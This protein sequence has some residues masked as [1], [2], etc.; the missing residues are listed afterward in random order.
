MQHCV[1]TTSNRG[2]QGRAYRAAAAP[3]VKGRAAVHQLPP[4]K[5][6]S[7]GRNEHCDGL[8]MR[9]TVGQA[10]HQ[11]SRAHLRNIDALLLDSPI[12]ILVAAIVESVDRRTI[13]AM[14]QPATCMGLQV[15][16]GN[17]GPQVVVWS[18]DRL[19]RHLICTT[20]A[21]ISCDS[22]RLLRESVPLF[23]DTR[24]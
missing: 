18:L 7:E 10:N 12:A 22:S 9:R 3:A 14:R 11:R 21:C 17:H 2:G 13:T 4:A 20:I 6:Q 8:Q 1:Q 5:L 19:A 23:S 24:F 15:A 16:G